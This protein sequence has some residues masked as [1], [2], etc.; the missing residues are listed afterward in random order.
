MLKVWFFYFYFLYI[1][2]SSAQTIT[3]VILPD[4]VIIM[5]HAFYIQLSHN[6]L[7]STIHPCTINQDGAAAYF[8]I[9][10]LTIVFS[11][12]IHAA[13]ILRWHFCENANNINLSCRLSLDAHGVQVIFPWQ[14]WNLTSYSLE[15]IFQ[16]CSTEPWS[17]TKMRWTSW[18]SLALHLKSD[19]LPLSQVCF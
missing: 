19:Q 12:Y 7:L 10:A 2:I 3:V 1:Y 5:K 6:I 11:Y 15:R 4:R 17:R 13:P 8:V 16:K 18:L 14:S 9:T